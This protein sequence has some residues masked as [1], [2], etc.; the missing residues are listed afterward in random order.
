VNGAASSA[1]IA[2]AARSARVGYDRAIDLLERLVPLARRLERAL[3]VYGV[4]VAAAALV[5]VG[6]LLAVDLPGTVWTWGLVIAL[7]AI[8]LVAPAIIL[9]FSSMLHAALELPGQ[10]RSLPDIAPARARELA[11]LAREAG[12][13]PQHERVGSIPRDSW[14]AGRLLNALRKEV[15]GVSVLLSMARVPFMVL[16]AAAI[17]VGGLE[18]LMAPFVV[19][20]AIVS[21]IV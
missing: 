4:V 18:I 5:I 12:A 10:F 2:G 3:R 17:L 9:L 14:R 16:V 20:A 7:L 11:S 8:L 6:A 19:M 21:T 13:R 1:R 15:P